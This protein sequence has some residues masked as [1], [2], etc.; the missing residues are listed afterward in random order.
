MNFNFSKN[1]SVWRKFM[2]CKPSRKNK[3][4]KK[5]TDNNRKYSDV[6]NGYNLENLKWTEVSKITSPWG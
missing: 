2:L 5:W 3:A 1:I 6:K 4:D